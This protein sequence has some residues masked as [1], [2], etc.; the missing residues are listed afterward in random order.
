MRDAGVV[1]IQPGIE[2]LSSE[3]LTHMHKGTSRI[4]HVRFLRWAREY[5]IHASYNILAGFP[6]EQASWYHDMTEFLPR[7]SHLQPP[8]GNINYVEMHRFSPLF[9]QRKKFEVDQLRLREDYMFNFP[10]GL[11]DPLKVGYFFNYH[12][13]ALTAR[14]QYESPLRAAL[15]AWLDAHTS[16]NPPTYEYRLGPQFTVIDDN[17]IG[18]TSR[19]ITLADLHQDV[20][21]LCDT[22]QSRSSLRRLLSPVRGSQANGDALDS[23]IADL[24]GADVLMSEGDLLL[25]LPTGA[26]PRTTRELYAYVL[27]AHAPADEALTEKPRPEAG[28]VHLPTPG[29]RPAEPILT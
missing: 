7:V 20:L 25:T 13:D 8:H 17:R 21:L 29:P 24:L 6:G 22:I 27:G 9:E 15:Q 1:T 11:I 28:P 3:L 23:V 18:R 26:R 2:S 4:R 19:R 12:S 5:H 10:P 14:E 16:Q